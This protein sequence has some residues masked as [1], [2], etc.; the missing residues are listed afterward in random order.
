MASSA[1]AHS[2]A[3][4]TRLPVGLRRWGYRLAYKVLR[5]YWFLGRPRANGVKCVLTRADDVLLVRHTYGRAEWE[6][7]GGRIQSRETPAAAATR[8]MREEL[9]ISIGD[10]TSV[11]RLTGR[12]DYRR[13]TLYCFRVAL[14]DPEL[15]LDRGEI[16]DAAWFPRDALPDDL[17]GY[18]R[19]ILPLLD[20][21][22]TFPP[23]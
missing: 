4:A 9:G 16:D 21:Q 19:R 18:V 8:E 11:G 5:V 20:G 1:Y 14:D 12:A 23:E 7:P 15:T 3:L 10:W 6:L 13:D 2:M 17:G 22:R